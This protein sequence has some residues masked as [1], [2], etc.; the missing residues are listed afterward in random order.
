MQSVPEGNITSLRS[1]TCRAIR[2]LKSNWEHAFW[3]LKKFCSFLYMA[4]KK[5]S[6]LP[7]CFTYFLQTHLNIFRF[8]LSRN[9]DKS[10]ETKIFPKNASINYYFFF[11]RGL[12]EIGTPTFFQHFFQY[13]Q[14]MLSTLPLTHPDNF[15]PPSM[16][17]P[18]LD[19]FG[20]SIY[21]ETQLSQI[22]FLPI[23]LWYTHFPPPNKPTFDLGWRPSSLTVV[24]RYFHRGA[25]TF[26]RVL[27]QSPR[28]SS[29][30]LNFRQS[31]FY[32]SGYAVHTSPYPTNQL[33]TLD[34]DLQVWRWSLD[35]LIEAP[36][37]FIESSVKVIDDHRGN[38][39]FANRFF[40]DQVM[41]YTLFHTYW[42][43]FQPWMTTFNFYDS[44]RY[45]DRGAD[46]FYR[47]LDQSHRW[48]SRKVNFHKSIFYRSGYAV[49]TF[50][51]LLIP[52]SN[53][54]NNF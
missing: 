42:Y 3:S 24:T 1:H 51:H 33:S 9:L 52:F 46:T 36:I 27:D 48:S 23:R 11:H 53:L 15:C 22:D 8:F 40:I 26:Y 43:H 21:E 31:I 25:D 37:L 54:D 2:M 44:H 12:D 49:H 17:P 30:E 5:L 19:T 41:L 16:T 13:S 32:R 28:W 4:W 7:P 10:I 38:S 29:R 47:V 14:V 34:D 20:W 50:P 18:I 39:T 6:I 35:T 45:F